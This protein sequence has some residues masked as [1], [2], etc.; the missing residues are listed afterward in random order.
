[1]DDKSV[2]P[3]VILPKRSRSHKVKGKVVPMVN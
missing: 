1:M 3:H 2:N